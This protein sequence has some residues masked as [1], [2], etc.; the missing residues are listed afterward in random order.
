[1]KNMI[2]TFA[3]LF[4]VVLLA[5]GEN[6]KPTFEKDGDMIKA[7][8]FHENGEIAQAGYLV[9]SKPHG[10]WVSFDTNGKKTAVAHYNEGVKIGKWFMWSGEKLTEIDYDNNKIVNVVKWDNANSMAT[11]P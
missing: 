1:M 10:E 11:N 2:L 6:I 8:Y 9:N 4:S 5:Q 7:T 3:M